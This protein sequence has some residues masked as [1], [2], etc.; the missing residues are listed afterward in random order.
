[1]DLKPFCTPEAAAAPGG[2]LCAPRPSPTLPR[3]SPLPHCPA[4]LPCAAST[5]TRSPASLLLLLLTPGD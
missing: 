3:P 5:P 4:A 2:T 1:M